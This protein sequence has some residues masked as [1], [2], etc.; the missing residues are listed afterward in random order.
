MCFKC[1][2][3]FSRTSLRKHVPKCTGMSFKH[4]HAILS[5]A[6][7]V[8]GNYH[9]I[10]TPQAIEVAC[11]IRDEEVHDEIRHDKSIILW[12]NAKARKRETAKA[13]QYTKIR[14][15]LIRLGRL[16]VEFKKNSTWY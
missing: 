14:S 6:D 3:R 1:K 4:K 11:K 8:E 10:A 13:H 12:L 16:K 15:N 7:V 5:S 9:V 2:C